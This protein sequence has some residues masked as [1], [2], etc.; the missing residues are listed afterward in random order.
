MTRSKT[1]SN[2]TKISSFASDASGVAVAASVTGVTP[3]VVDA[4]TDKTHMVSDAMINDGPAPSSTGMDV[5]I[6]KPSATTAATAV[7]APPGISRRPK[8]YTRPTIAERHDHFHSDPPNSATYSDVEVSKPMID[9]LGC[10]CFIALLLQPVADTPNQSTCKPCCLVPGN[11][12]LPLHRYRMKSPSDSLCPWY[13][14]ACCKQLVAYAHHVRNFIIPK[15]PKLPPSALIDQ[16]AVLHFVLAVDFL[17]G[18]DHLA[19][20]RA[21]IDCVQGGYTPTIYSIFS[22]QVA[23]TCHVAWIQSTFFQT[24]NCARLCFLAA[25]TSLPMD[26]KWNHLVP[27]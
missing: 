19:L 2:Q 11:L 13:L 18:L 12:R 1:R 23:T 4:I 27:A 24:H 5:T 14:S 16:S 3:P 10:V 7:P 26:G 6:N 21:P 25:D 9:I 22:A 17:A 15:R 20:L 8:I